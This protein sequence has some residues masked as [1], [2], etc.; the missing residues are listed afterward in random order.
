MHLIPQQTSLDTPSELSWYPLYM[1]YAPGDFLSISK[2]QTWTTVWFFGMI[3]DKI[4][5]SSLLL[6][7]SYQDFIPNQLSKSFN[8]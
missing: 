7:A 8:T 2:D 3:M 5:N 1:L 6:M 4:V